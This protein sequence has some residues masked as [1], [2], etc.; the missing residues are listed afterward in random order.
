MYIYIHFYYPIWI[1]KNW[2]RILLFVEKALNLLN[3]YLILCVESD[4]LKDQEKI[5]LLN[6]FLKQIRIEKF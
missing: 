4:L 1:A 5:S 3:L 2:K 6:F